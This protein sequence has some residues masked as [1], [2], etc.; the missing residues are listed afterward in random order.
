LFRSERFAQLWIKPA[1]VSWDDSTKTVYVG[2]SRLKL[3]LRAGDKY[4][5][6]NGRYL[7]FGAPCFISNGSLMA[8]VRALARAFDADVKWNGELCR[9]MITMGSGAIESGDAFY[10]ADDLYWL[11]RIISAEARGESLEGQIAVGN[12][13]LNRLESKRW[14][15]RL[16]KSYSTRDAV[17]SFR[18]QPTGQFIRN[19]PKRR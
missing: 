7:Y 11:S 17:S 6:A 13:V 3:S 15:T 16:R 12:V 19:L 9:V 4:L 2:T 10:N 8:P 1:A 5:I 14:R 18:R